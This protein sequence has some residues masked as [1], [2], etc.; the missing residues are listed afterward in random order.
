MTE[1]PFYIDGESFD[2]L[3]PQEGIERSFSILDS[4]KAGRSVETG[5]PMI[6]DILGTFFN[7]KITIDPKKASKNDYDRLF[8]IFAS[9]VDSHRVKVP[10]NQ[11]WLS[12]EAY[13]T[14]GSDRVV[15]MKNGTKYKGLSVD[16][17]AVKAQWIP[18]EAMPRGYTED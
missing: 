8:M 5:A 18:G 3:V 11:G 17:I 6:R 2:V 1:Y 9:P 7:Y 4:D 10:F 13:V 16:M 14:Q 15:I 12:F